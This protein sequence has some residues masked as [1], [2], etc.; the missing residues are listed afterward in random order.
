MSHT[1]SYSLLTLL[2]DYLGKQLDNI[3]NIYRM[4]VKSH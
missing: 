2:T 1:Q 3:S 4:S